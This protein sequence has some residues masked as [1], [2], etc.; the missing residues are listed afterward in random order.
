MTILRPSHSA[1][2]SARP[3]CRS[4]STRNGDGLRLRFRARRRSDGRPFQ[5]V[6]VRPRG[7]PVPPSPT[8][9]PTPMHARRRDAAETGRKGSPGRWQ[10]RLVFDSNV[11]ETSPVVKGTWVTV[12]HVVSLIVDGWTWSDILRVHPE[13]TEDDIRD[14]PRLHRRRG[15]RRL[16]ADGRTGCGPPT[17]LA[18]PAVGHDAAP[19]SVDDLQLRHLG[20]LD[21][22]DADLGGELLDDAEQVGAARA[23]RRRGRRSSWPSSPL[24]RRLMFSGTSPR[25]GTPS[26]SALRRAPPRPKR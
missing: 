1:S 3:R 4:R 9:S 24:S 2:T 5:R 12:G 22:L 11:S 10:D 13:L 6:A 26:S 7:R 20:R 17:I 16:S 15:R 14:L 19:V 18:C 8:R 21:V 25:N 23:S